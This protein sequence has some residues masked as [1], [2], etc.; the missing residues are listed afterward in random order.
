[1]N[2]DSEF[3]LAGVIFYSSGLYSKISPGWHSKTSQI[4]CSVLNRTAFAFP[5]FKMERFDIVMPTFSESSVKDIFLRA[6]I[7]SRFTIMGMCCF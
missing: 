1:M 7:T 2:I 5:F 6:S 4:A 3:P